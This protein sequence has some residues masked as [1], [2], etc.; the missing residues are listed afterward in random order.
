TAEEANPTLEIALPP[1]PPLAEAE[2]PLEAHLP[3]GE[4]SIQPEFEESDFS[5]ARRDVTEIFV[6]VGRRDGVTPRDFYTLLASKGLGDELTGHGYVKVK[7]R[8]SFVGVRRALLEQAISALN[9]ATI[10]GKLAL[11]EPSRG[12]RDVR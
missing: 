11:A 1:A 7:H 5:E 9:G 8:H 6:N 10:A 4:R 12:F 3:T 2:L